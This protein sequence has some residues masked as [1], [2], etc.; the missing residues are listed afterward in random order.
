[1]SAI[2]QL[3]SRTFIPSPKLRVTHGASNLTP[4]EIE[5]LEGVSKGMTTQ[6]IAG[7]LILSPHTILTHRKH[8][9]RKLEALN[10]A[11]M[12]RIAFERGF[13]N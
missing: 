4:R 7:L 8:L 1:M 9:L 12:I 10:T 5:V 3:S 11:N 6:E 13:L 2:K